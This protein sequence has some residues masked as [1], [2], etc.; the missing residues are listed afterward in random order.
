MRWRKRNDVT[1]WGRQPKNTSCKFLPSAW[2]T[3][4]SGPGK[5]TRG[6]ISNPAQVQSGCWEVA[7]VSMA[8]EDFPKEYSDLAE[9]S[10]SFGSGLVLW[11]TYRTK[12]SGRF[13]FLL[14]PLLYISPWIPYKSPYWFCYKCMLRRKLKL[15]KGVPQN[16]REFWFRPSI[17]PEMHLPLI[18]KQII[19]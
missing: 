8:S 5:T 9:I 7:E 13:F 11:Q 3:Y 4:H 6:F 18:N 15:S 16:L 10:G 14:T 17:V 1:D 2:F 12:I 19:R